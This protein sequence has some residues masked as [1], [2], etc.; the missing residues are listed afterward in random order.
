MDPVIAERQ[1]T[2]EKW[3]GKNSPNISCAALSALEVMRD[4]KRIDTHALLIYVDVAVH[5]SPTSNHK[6]KF[7]HSVRD[8]R[9]VTMSH[10][11]NMLQRRFAGGRTDVERYLAPRPGVMRILIIDD[12]L[13]L[14]FD[15]YTL[16]TTIDKIAG[17]LAP[18]NAS[19][20]SDLQRVV[21]EGL[22]QPLH[23]FV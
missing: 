17:T 16:P 22:V 21:K 18:F 20:L 7:V 9:C 15:A 13:P 5:M 14:P 10:V 1:V 3:C 19:W 23:I 12:G 8:A 11:H 2:F 6:P 4:M